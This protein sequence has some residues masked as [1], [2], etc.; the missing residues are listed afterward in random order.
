MTTPSK[1]LD[2]VI[3]G[4]G[5]AG[6]CAAL[7]LDQAGYRPVVYE[8][9][10][11]LE[12][13]GVGINL[14]P[15]A[16]RELTELGLL[17]D[18]RRIGVEIEDLSY[19]TKHGKSIWGEPRGLKAGYQWPQIAI[20]RG[21]LQMML[22]RKVQARLGMDA[23]VFGHTLNAVKTSDQGV[24]ATFIDR[25]TGQV[26]IER[27]ADL[28]VGADGIHSAVRKVFYPNEGPPKWNHR[29][30]WR[31]TTKTGKVLGGRSMLWAGHAR[32]KFV[33]YPIKYDPATGETLLNWICELKLDDEQLLARE[34]WN[35]RGDR[36]DFLPPFAD[37][38]WPGVDVPALVNASGDIYEFPMVDRDPL[39]AWTFGRT[40]LLGDA[41]HA[42]YPVGSNGATQGILDA[43]VFAYHL[44]TAPTVAD[45]LARYEAE[46]R[47]ATARIVEMNR[48]EG[49]DSVMELA[50][51]RAPNIDDDLDILL[52]VEERQMIADGYKKVAGFDPKTLNARNSHT[53]LQPVASDEQASSES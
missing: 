4:G 49:P 10:P 12:P 35:K 32:Q 22:V 9:V 18:L 51:Q 41:A 38:R 33:A 53:V 23:I 14:L 24:T 7:A 44:A 28:L 5:I 11:K 36:A 3:I 45:G 2:I 17:E 39:P 43:R 29:V 31:S 13:L 42:M 16:M 19:L 30:L 48:R 52:P 25:R 6:L 15:H 37:W 26:L 47:P 40:T 21:E 34:D 1:P 20:H 8:A 50:E 46:R 27:K